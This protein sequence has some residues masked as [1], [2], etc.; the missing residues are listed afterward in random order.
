MT[1]PQPAPA[2]ASAVAPETKREQLESLLRDRKLDRTLT[3]TLPALGDAAIAAFGLAA[4]DA[5]LGGGLP[6]G[7][8]SE[9]VGPASTGRTSLAMAWLAAA[10]RRDESVALI[11]AF[12]RFDPASAAACGIQ[13]PRLLWVRGQAVS[14]TGSAVDPAWL[15][16]ARAVEGPG[17][18]IERTLDRAIK[19][20]NLVLQ[21]GVCTAVVFDVAD[22]PMSALRRVPATTWFRMQR[23]IEASETACLLL[24]SQPLA[25]SAGGVTIT[26]GLSHSDAHL[27]TEAR[28]NQRAKVEWS[29]DHDRARRLAGLSISMRIT[30]PRRTAAGDVV[31]T[32]QSRCE[33]GQFVSA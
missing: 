20:L 17:T 2:F 24:G 28:C 7:H 5:R 6:R 15:P 10:T 18:M 21:A 8:V 3:T 23:V 19:A 1:L 31:L 4:L 25:R 27:S 26:T 16:G 32:S 13:L 33:F 29:G 14:K 30:S 22:V 9:I 12:D 11:D